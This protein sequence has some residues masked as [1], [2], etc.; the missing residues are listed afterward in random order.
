M[1]SKNQGLESSTQ[2]LP[3]K[4]A[5]NATVVLL[6]KERQAILQ[7]RVEEID[8]LMARLDQWGKENPRHTSK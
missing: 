4:E 5:N 3:S 2:L 7:N 6:C 1:S 8:G